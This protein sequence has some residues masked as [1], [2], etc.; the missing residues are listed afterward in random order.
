M[1]DEDGGVGNM[2]TIPPVNFLKSLCTLS[3][4]PWVWF[5]LW[6]SGG[7]HRFTDILN[8]IGCSRTKLSEVLKVLQREGLIIKVWSRYQAVSPAW[9][10][11]A[12]RT[13]ALS[14]RIDA[15]EAR[16]E[17]MESANAT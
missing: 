7:A 6:E 4:E 8:I 5:I 3:L 2:G 15:I 12:R 11:R 13:H 17:K 9:L 16:I 1:S 10:V 14:E